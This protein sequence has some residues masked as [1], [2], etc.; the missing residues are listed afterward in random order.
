MKLDRNHSPSAS[1]R[2]A[3]APTLVTND[4]RWATGTA[5]QV[6]VK[7]APTSQ[8]ETAARLGRT[9]K[10]APNHHHVAGP[11]HKHPVAILTTVA[12]RSGACSAN[13]DYVEQRRKRED[14]ERLTTGTKSMACSSRRNASPSDLGQ[15]CMVLPCCS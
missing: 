12:A 11:E 5:H 8:K 7:V 3:W 9:T 4:S 14:H 15:S 13:P 6:N 2:S 10:A 1:R